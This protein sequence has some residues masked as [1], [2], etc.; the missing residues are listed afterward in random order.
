MDRKMLDRT[1][2]GVL[3]QKQLQPGK[4]SARLRSHV[5]SEQVSSLSFSSTS[6]V[7][8]S[9]SIAAQ[10]QSAETEEGFPVGRRQ[11]AQVSSGHACSGKG[12]AGYPPVR[13]G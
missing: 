10:T 5:L 6:W 1:G 7:V 13:T 3:N 4:A 11:E 8:P 2:M 9:S 12:Q